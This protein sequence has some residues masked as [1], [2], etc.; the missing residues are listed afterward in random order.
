[1]ASDPLF[2]VSVLHF[3]CLYVR[4]AAAHPQG[5]RAG[6]D[7]THVAECP[8]MSHTLSFSLVQRED[9]RARVRYL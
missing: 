4:D 9:R 8:I 2:T 7:D 1:M 5:G 3:P 6:S